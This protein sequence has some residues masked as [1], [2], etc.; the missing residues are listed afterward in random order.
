MPVSANL[1][2][3]GMETKRLFI[4]TDK[5]FIADLPRFTFQG[6]IVVVQSAGE[7]AR[8][9]RMLRRERETGIDTETR[10]VF[11]KGE[12][13][14]VALLQVSTESVCF[15][16]R[17]CQTGL[18]PEMLSFLSDP[19]ILKVGLSLS[20]DLHMLRQRA[21]LDPAN[22]L[23]LQN[24]VAEMGIEDRGLQRL[25]A[26]VF[27]M[28]LA[29]RAQRSNWEA[30]VL[31]DAQKVYAATDAYTCLQLYHELKR[32]RETGQYTLVTA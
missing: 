22:W 20:D 27:R 21:D 15:L 31:T 17:L 4:K 2:H 1:Q 10:P 14:K 32:L 18:T 16:F 29:K 28:R 12:V 26:N 7:A 23:D 6:K 24:Y 5:A 8:A 3:S 9:V 30:D 19:G 13:H 25:Y 11:R